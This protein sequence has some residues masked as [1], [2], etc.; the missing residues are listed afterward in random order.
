MGANSTTIGAGSLGVG[1]RIPGNNV[2]AAAC[3]SSDRRKATL[4]EG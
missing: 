2:I 3:R 4:T 1:T